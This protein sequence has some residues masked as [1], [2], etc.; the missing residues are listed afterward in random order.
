MP[1]SDID[2]HI[3]SL[4]VD[5]AD[6]QAYQSR[7]KKGGKSHP[8][9]ASTNRPN[10]SSSSWLVVFTFLLV[11]VSLGG[12][13]WLYQQFVSLQSALSESQARINEL[14]ETLSATGE[15]MGESAV[16]MQVR[17]TQLTEKTDQ[18]W[19]QMDKLWA[20]AW[21]R[22]QNE[23]KALEKQANSQFE[24]AKKMS[25]LLQSS[26]DEATTSLGLLDEQI[27]LIEEDKSQLKQAI[28]LSIKTNEKINQQIKNMQ[29]TL[30]EAG[31]DRRNLA[32]RLSSVERK[33]Q[34][35]DT[36]GNVSSAGTR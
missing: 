15:E 1:S 13:A 31:Q 16:A 20:S 5:Q 28:T 26:V 25:A 21:K 34:N 29:E 18:L 30:I 4:S 23:I 6:R 36:A 11:C 10:K 27:Q 33:Q 35:T 12:G 2:E 7:G 24:D 9:P 8:Q 19:E 14:E 32:R 17:V 22:N 3:P